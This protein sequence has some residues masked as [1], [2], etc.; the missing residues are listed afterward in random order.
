MCVA[1]MLA[2]EHIAL[3]YGTLGSALKVSRLT[4][5]ESKRR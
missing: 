2:E 4:H 3:R 1:L 5:A